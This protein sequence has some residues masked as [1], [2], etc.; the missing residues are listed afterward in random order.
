M[1][2]ASGGEARIVRVRDACVGS[3]REG[4]RPAPNS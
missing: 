3:A 4:W 2:G 1:A